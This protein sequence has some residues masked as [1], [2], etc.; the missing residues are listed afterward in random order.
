MRIAHQTT[1]DLSLRFLVLPQL[2]AVAAA[3]DESVGISGPGIYV[4]DLVA[5]G[6]R[7]IAL[8]TSTRGMSLR[9]D[10]AAAA[11]LWQVL[12]QEDFQVLHTHNPKPGIYGRL[13]AR[14]AGV[15]HVVNTVHGL[16]AT[17]DDRWL[18]RSLVY[19][20]EVLAARFSHAELI[21]NPEDLA[22]LSR[23]PFYPRRRA[24]LLGNGV[25]LERFD[26]R[27]FANGVRDELRRQ[28]DIEDGQVAVG[29]VGRLVAEK[30]Y[31]EFFA[32]ARQLGP[33]YV[34]F[35][36]G[37]SDPE[38]ADALP[39]DLL[40]DAV[41]SGVRLLGMRTDVESLYA[42]LDVFVLPSHREGFPRA[43]MEAAAM[44]LP[45]VATDI[46]GCRQVVEHGVNGLLV[47]LGD[48]AALTDAIRTIGSDMALAQQMGKAGRHKAEAEFDERE[49]VERV[50][51]TYA[52][53]QAVHA[54][55]TPKRR[56]FPGTGL[57]AP[58]GR[59][60]LDTAAA[61]TLRAMSGRCAG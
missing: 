59:R 43:A 53:L 17:E 26:C 3:G 1:T 29:M 54:A 31:P 45:V 24:R 21:Q 4:D 16:F 22:L 52:K 11:T 14:M 33:E 25:D 46:R 57:F 15:P 2:L 42:C 23:L 20:V 37:P 30:G 9:A 32:A 44:S 60:L 12:R 50:M 19:A 28:L 47:P 7:H 55:A 58:A 39:P 8:P 56:P 5:L 34:V 51:S 27:H 6:I 13:L 35:A 18:R 48:V 41:A 36:V 49:V 61:A 38:K 40:A 10:V